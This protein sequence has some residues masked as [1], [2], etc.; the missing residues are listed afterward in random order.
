[1]DK[2][3]NKILIQNGWV[4][5]PEMIGKLDILVE[6]ETISDI[7]ENIDPGDYG[8]AKIIDATGKIVMPGGI[9]V[10]THFNLD[11]GIAV[12]QDDFYTGTVAAAMGGT[13][14]IVDHPGF[15]PEGCSIFH[16]IEKFIRLKNIMGL[17]GIML[18]LIIH[19]MACSS[20]WMVRY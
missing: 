7:G 5:T 13:T 6:G 3:S 9:D 20:I 11:V 14:T 17:Q 2:S 16:Q 18:L 1:M 4:V 15:G 12:A 8:D 10:H 19:F